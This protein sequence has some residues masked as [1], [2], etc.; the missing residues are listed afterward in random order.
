M[1][2]D[3]H[4]HPGVVS[5]HVVDCL[6]LPLIPVCDKCAEAERKVGALKVQ[7][8]RGYFWGFPIVVKE[9]DEILEAEFIEQWKHLT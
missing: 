5:T 6:T 2:P 3:C 7:K 8:H 4:Y 1:T 9:K